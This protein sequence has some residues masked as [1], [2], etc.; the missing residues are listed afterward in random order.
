MVDWWFLPRNFGLV[1][2]TYEGLLLFCECTWGAGSMFRWWGY[3]NTL[4]LTELF[5]LFAPTGGGEQKLV[6]NVRARGLVTRRLKFSEAILLNAEAI[7]CPGRE[8]S[9]PPQRATS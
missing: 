8:A 1:V 6:K 5:D 7:D 2:G 4:C 9:C 3:L